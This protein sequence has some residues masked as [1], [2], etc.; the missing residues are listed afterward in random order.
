MLKKSEC[1][2]DESIKFI[3]LVP[4][5]NE[6]QILVQTVAALRDGLKSFPG[7][8]V[9]L[10]ENGSRDQSFR[11]AKEL[12]EESDTFS[13]KCFSTNN[14]GMGAAYRLGLENLPALSASWRVVFTAADLPFGFSDLES[15]LQGPLDIALA[16]GSK[17]HSLSRVKR[18]WYRWIMSF[19][20]QTARR[21]LL[22]AKV[23]DS[24]GTLFL[25]ADLV[26]EAIT[27]R[28]NDFF[29]T[30]ELVNLAEQQ[31]WEVREMPVVLKP[32]QRP[33][34]VKPLR[35]GW[36]MFKQL[37]ELRRREQRL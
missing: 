1:K 5:H 17:S 25:R 10:L 33:S 32:E 20:F 12:T 35:H 29:F 19:C 15:Y 36:T 3:Y 4:I 23:R 6:A 7:S 18:A 22:G 37:W 9:Y 31:R 30:T 2:K 21:A 16:I 13:V 34:T 28:A 27:V 14:A 8:Q 24:Q 26:G 11:L